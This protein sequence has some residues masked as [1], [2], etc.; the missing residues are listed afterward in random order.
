MVR[1]L[2]LKL[3]FN[4]KATL[5]TVPESENK[6]VLFYL[7]YVLNGFGLVLVLPSIQRKR[8]ANI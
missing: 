2:V 6:G 7:D 8:K 5:H 4:I 3:G 1:Q